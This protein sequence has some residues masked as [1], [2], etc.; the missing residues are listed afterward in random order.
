[1]LAV[2]CKVQH[3]IMFCIYLFL[4]AQ[5]LEYEPK[6]EEEQYINCNVNEE[7]R[8]SAAWNVTTVNIRP[9]VRLLYQQ[10]NVWLH[11]FSAKIICWILVS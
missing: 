6:T 8:D 5:D 10:C 3:L 7:E 2:S 4:S 9:E 11:E 1:M